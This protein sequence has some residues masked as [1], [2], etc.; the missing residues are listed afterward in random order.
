[1]TKREYYNLQFFKKSIPGFSTRY[2]CD[3]KEKTTVNIYLSSLLSDLGEKE[4]P[5]LLEEIENALNNRHYEQYYTIDGSMGNNDLEI[6]P[7]N[8]L[9]HNEFEMPLLELKQILEEW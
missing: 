7:P 8:A 2:Y 9:I 1:M 3:V 5:Y 6:L 4:S